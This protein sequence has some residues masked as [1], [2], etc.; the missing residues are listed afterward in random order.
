VAAAD[1]RRP[2]TQGERSR[3]WVAA[4][5]WAPTIISP[6]PPPPPHHAKLSEEGRRDPGRSGVDNNPLPL[7]ERTQN[8]ALGEAQ[9]SQVPGF[10]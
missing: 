8:P 10:C 4:P 7:R 3:R 2:A 5:P 9:R 6:P 1:F